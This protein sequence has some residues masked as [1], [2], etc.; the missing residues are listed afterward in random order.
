MPLVHTA[1][2]WAGDRE[3]WQ[4]PAWRA[5][6]SRGP[7]H[8]SPGA[9]QCQPRTYAITGSKTLHLYYYAGST[10]VCTKASLQKCG[11][12]LRASEWGGLFLP[13][14]SQ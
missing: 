1:R 10:L 3:A 6:P 7:E 2:A 9:T 13:K 4:A 14:P 8:T 12:D 5:W 11:L